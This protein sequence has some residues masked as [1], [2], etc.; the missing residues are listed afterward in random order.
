MPSSPPLRSGKEEIEEEEEEGEGEMEHVKINTGASTFANSLGREAAA[1]EG[2]IEAIKERSR[3]MSMADA[4]K[5]GL[6]ESELI[7]PK[8]ETWFQF[9]DWRV[10]A[11]VGMSVNA[12]FDRNLIALYVLSRASFP[13][14][15]PPPPPP[16]TT[17]RAR[18]APRRISP[19]ATWTSTALPTPTRPTTIASRAW[20]RPRWPRASKPC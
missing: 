3:P 15:A 6:A 20:P 2:G 19:C 8:D 7:N 1:R 9:Y 16:T 13:T 4:Q 10:N 11:W 12:Q 5:L 18:C 14:R 17:P